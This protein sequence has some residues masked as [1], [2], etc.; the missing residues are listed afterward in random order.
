MEIFVVSIAT[1]LTSFILNVIITPVIIRLSHRYKWYDIPDKRKIHTGLIPRLGGFG[2]FVS[3]MLAF[4]IVI[5]A[6][7]LIGRT[8][9]EASIPPSA[10]FFFIPLILIHIT[11]LIDD[12]HNLKALFKFIIQLLAASIVTIGGY[13]IRDLTIPY[14]GTIHLGF[15]AYPATV[16]WIVGITNAL[17]L[18]DGMD[19]L[20][21]GI[22]GFAALSL[23][24]IMMIKGNMLAGLLSFA[25]LGAIFGF[26]FFNFPPAKIFMG[27][28]GSLFLGFSLSVIPLIPLKNNSP[29]PGIL[30]AAIT[31]FMIPIIDTA[32]A[33]LRRLHEGRPIYSPDRKHLH[34]RLLGIGLGER[35]ILAIIYSFSAYLSAVA[36]TSMVLP[37]EAN[38]YFISIIWIGSLLAYILFNFIESKKLD[39]EQ[40]GAERKVREK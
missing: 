27:D 33:I 5:L 39:S 19:G 2:M 9:I 28:S 40:S 17:N 37:K 36:I 24:I 16:L 10:L 11:G 23:G 18:V 21:G 14:L 32:T 3:A 25:I 34:H 29:F 1:V 35:K 26:L 20:A 31:L 12:F 6:S 30:I 13:L 4:V 15:I 22:A 38:I 8:A 7:R